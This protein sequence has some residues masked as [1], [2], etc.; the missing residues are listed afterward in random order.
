MLSLSLSLSLPLSLS[1]SLSYTHTHTQVID[2]GAGD[3]SA[4]GRR[5]KWEGDEDEITHFAWIL[6]SECLGSFIFTKAG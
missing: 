2:V 6:P 5:E 3:E 4:E 1:L